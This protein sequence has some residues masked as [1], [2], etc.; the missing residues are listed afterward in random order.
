MMTFPNPGASALQ[1]VPVAEIAQLGGGQVQGYGDDGQMM[2]VD[3]GAGPHRFA[4][5]S[6][7]S[8]HTVI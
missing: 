7:H 1:H 5:K 6:F 2:A 3:A 4:R 8:F